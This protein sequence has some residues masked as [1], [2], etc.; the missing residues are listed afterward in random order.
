MKYVNFF[1][2][3]DEFSY[4]SLQKN[5]QTKPKMCC[6]LHNSLRIKFSA[7][8]CSTLILTIGNMHTNALV[9][10]SYHLQVRRGWQRLV[11]SASGSLDLVDLHEV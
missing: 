2:F 7:I 10:K 8:F 9:K 3:Y 11:H 6:Y 4:P 5:Q 1:F